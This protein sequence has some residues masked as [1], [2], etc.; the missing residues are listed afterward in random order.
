M[1][2][3]EIAELT[4]KEHRNVMRDIR[5]MLAELHGEDRL[6]SFEQTVQRPN[7]S[8]GAPIS[9]TVYVLP[10]RETLTLESGYGVEM[11][12]QVDKGVVATA[13]IGRF[14]DGGR[15]WKATFHHPFAYA[16]WYGLVHAPGVALCGA[17]VRSAVRVFAGRC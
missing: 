17:F 10:K 2:S 3:R 1:T 16:Q 7:P 11:R 13:P 5:T 4:G 8:G 6:L 12:A 14:R 9:S 15:S